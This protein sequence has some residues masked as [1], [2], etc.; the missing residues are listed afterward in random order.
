MILSKFFSAIRSNGSSSLEGLE[1]LRTKITQQDLEHVA[2][3]MPRLNKPIRLSLDRRI[4]LDHTAAFRRALEAHPEIRRPWPRNVVA[5]T[6]EGFKLKHVWELN[7]Y[8]RSLLQQQVD[9]D[10]DSSKKKDVP[11]SIWPT[12]LEKANDNPDVLF[13]FLKGP[14]F[15]CSQNYQ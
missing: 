2:T 14:A 6:E 8:G 1:L 4:L 7:W 15:A 3:T 13:T 9:D 11:L 12:V 5:G 10:S